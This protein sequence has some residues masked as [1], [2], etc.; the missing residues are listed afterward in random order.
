[1]NMVKKELTREQLSCLV[2]E[3]KSGKEEAFEDLLDATE[4]FARRLAFA[5]VGRELLDD[6]V[7]ESFLSVYLH[8]HQLRDEHA[9][10]SWLS[11]IVLHACYRLQKKHPERA[12][13]PESAKCPDSTQRVV[14]SIT[15]QM[16]LKRL[17]K[18]DR[19]VLTLHELLGLNHA[20]VGHALHIPEG[21]ARSRLHTARKRLKKVLGERLH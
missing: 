6:V 15:L 19:E 12:E 4:G 8:L 16:A 9:F 5:T 10:L 7:Q 2:K 1:M 20:E 14:D 3:A 21:T 13:L 11:R 17:P 18:T